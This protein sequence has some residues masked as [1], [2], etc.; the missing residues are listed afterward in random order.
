[1]GRKGTEAAKQASQMVLADDNFASIAAAVREGR[2]VYDNLMKVIGWTLPTNG[3][4]ALTILAALAL[5]LALPITPVQILWV[6][7]VT[8]VA[9][10]LTLAFEPTEPGAM[11]RPPRDPAEPILSGRLMAQVAFV[12]VLLAAGCFGLFALAKAQGLPLEVARTMAVNALVA[13]ELFY[14]FSARYAHGSALTAEGLKGTPA[15]WIGVAVTVTAQAGFTFLP[16]ANVVFGSA[17]LAAGQIALATGA[18]V[19]VLL[20]AEAR[21]AL[22]RRLAPRATAP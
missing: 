3:G 1:M 12:S 9:L 19:A 20:A 22:A 17:P 8:A 18:G 15:V 6:N 7:M 16:A 2:T 10:G 11:R 21:K 4:E 5:G 13:M 14:L